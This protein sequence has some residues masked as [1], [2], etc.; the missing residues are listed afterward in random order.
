MMNGWMA[1][2]T[3]D[4][5]DGRWFIHGWVGYRVGLLEKE[6]GRG[7]MVFLLLELCRRL[8]IPRR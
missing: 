5:D 8:C 4:D 1:S 3:G 6:D 7:E 2:R